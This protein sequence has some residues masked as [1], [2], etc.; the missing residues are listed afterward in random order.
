MG[1]D[2]YLIEFIVVFEDYTLGAYLCLLCR[3]SKPE[4]FEESSGLCPQ[5]TY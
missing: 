5:K 4:S 3:R 1:N 2:L